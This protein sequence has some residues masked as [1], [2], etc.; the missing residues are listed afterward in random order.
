MSSAARPLACQC[1]TPEPGG[2][3]PWVRLAAAAFLAMHVMSLSLSVNLSET[4]PRERLLLHAALI[5]GTLLVAALAGAPLAVNA[6]RELRARRITIEALFL[7][8]IAGALGQSVLAAAAGSGPVYWEVVAILLVVYALGR[9]LVTRSQQAAFGVLSRSRAGTLCELVLDDGSTRA[10]AS[11]SL[12]AGDVVLVKPGQMVPVDGT[13]AAGQACLQEAQITGEG[14]LR[15]VRAGDPVLAGVWPVDAAIQVRAGAPA[16]ASLYAGALDE[17]G[18]SL[19]SPARLERAAD[20][21]AG[22]FAPVVL[23]A[24]LATTAGWG[25]ARGWPEGLTNGLAVLLI[26]CPC[27][28][29]FATPLAFWS[30]LRRLASLGVAAR[31]GETVERLATAGTVMLDKTGTLTSDDWTISRA[32]FLAVPGLDE[33]LLRRMIAAAERSSGHPVA[34]AFR[35]FDAGLDGLPVRVE[36]LRVLP[37]EGFEA[38]LGGFD[39]VSWS[40]S[41]GLAD[42]QPDGAARRLAARVDGRPAA[43]VDLEES[44]LP[45]ARSAI[46]ELHAVGLETILATGDAAVRARAIPAGRHCA[47]LKPADKTALVGQLQSE[48]RR[49]L[50]VG[51]GLNDSA[52]MAAAHASLAA[53]GSVDLTSSLAGGVLLGHDL[54]AIPRAIKTARQALGVARSNLYFAAAYNTAG[55]ALA[56]AGLVHPITSVLVMTC[57]SLFVSWRAARLLPG[58]PAS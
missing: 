9:R 39:G 41:I 32:E 44:V 18:R 20:R 43:F 2:I 58:E 40:L 23:G 7:L 56:A 19:K 35:S 46:E 50:F 25:L 10:V 28:M 34:R 26:A 55:I 21:L 8:G 3:W 36:S 11:G 22:W 47:S 14:F 53:P 49:V 1:H 17:V 45:S 31:G 51:D 16:A 13:I 38:R 33:P 15:A 54:G 4:T 48:G 52:A 5:G 29:G 37:G 30:A 6:W 42:E 27:A 57:S 24:A 12:E